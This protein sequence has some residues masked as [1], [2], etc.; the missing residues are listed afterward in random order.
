MKKTISILSILGSITLIGIISCSKQSADTLTTTPTTPTTPV[1]S[2]CDTSAVKY[3]ADITSILQ[4]NCYS[5]HGS[6]NTGGSGGI[7]LEGYSNL[8][9][10]ADNGKL[11]GNVTHASGFVAMP[12]GLP[13]LPDCQV[14][15]IVAWVHQGALNN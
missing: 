4:N 12:Y 7:L 3:S 8:K 2:Q 1:T 13:K 14:N 11:V 6:G 15:K 10:W 5:C 9:I